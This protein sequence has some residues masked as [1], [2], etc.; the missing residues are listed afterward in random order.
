[1]RLVSGTVRRVAGGLMIDPLAVA[2]EGTIVV[3]DLAAP[4]GRADSL[5]YGV[6]PSDPLADALTQAGGL[7]A[8][9]AHRG[10]AH[11]PASFAE[12]LRA[13]AATLT[14]LGLR[15]VADALDGLAG[16]LGPDPS[17]SAVESWVDAALFVATASEL[18]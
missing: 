15:R 10:L 9:G 6:I 12:R 8:E 1:M 2:A 11:L 5:P 4:T 16:A 14:G 13:E 17:D 18:R 3:P 7:L